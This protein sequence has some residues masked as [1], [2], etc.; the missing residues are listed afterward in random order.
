MSEPS[1]TAT[2]RATKPHQHGHL[3]ADYGSAGGWDHD[4]APRA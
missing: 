2:G 4:G 3:M 1:S